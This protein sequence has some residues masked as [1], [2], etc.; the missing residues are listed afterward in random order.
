MGEKKKE[1]L[2]GERVHVVL[3]LHTSHHNLNLHTLFFLRRER[4]TGKL[5]HWYILKKIS[6]K[7]T[8]KFE[9]LFIRPSNQSF[10]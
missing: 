9:N 3:F 8:I 6:N 10:S 1:A 4:V 2:W 5:V 7:K